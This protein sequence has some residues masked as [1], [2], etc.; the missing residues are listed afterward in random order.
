MDQM[1]APTL[2]GRSLS[3]WSAPLLRL[4]FHHLGMA[5]LVHARQVCRQWYQAGSDETLQAW[6]F[7]QAFPACHRRQLEKAFDTSRARQYLGPWYEELTPQMR[8]RVDLA[9]RTGQGLP[10]RTLFFVLTQQ[11]VQ[12]PLFPHDSYSSVRYDQRLL[13]PPL[14]IS[15]DSRWLLAQSEAYGPER[16]WGQWHRQ[17]NLLQIREEGVGEALTQ[18][19]DQTFL[20]VLPSADSRTFWALGSGG[21][22][23]TWQKSTNTGAW[24]KAAPASLCR[25][26]VY[27]AHTSADSLYLAVL[28]D[29][30]VLLFT[31]AATAGWQQQWTWPL[32]FLGY[33]V[34]M[35]PHELPNR[36]TLLF[37]QDSRHLMVEVNQMLFLAHRRGTDWQE[38]AITG[39]EA[40]ARFNCK[41]SAL[42]PC[43]QFLAFAT[44]DNAH[45]RPNPPGICAEFH[46]SLC[47]FDPDAGW[48][49]I[50]HQ[51]C[52][53]NSPQ[54]WH[55][56]PMAFCPGGGQLAFPCRQTDQ[57]ISLC[58]LTAGEHD[59]GQSR[60]TLVFGQPTVFNGALFCILDAL[61]F[62][63]TG[64][65]LGAVSQAGVQI[66]QRHPVLGWVSAAWV[67]NRSHATFVASVQCVF[68]PDGCHCAL[69]LGGLKGE[70]CIWG[71]DRQGRYTEKLHRSLG[72]R[73][74]LGLQFSPDASQLVVISAAFGDDNQDTS[75]VELFRL[76]PCTRP[77]Q[78][79]ALS[80]PPQLPSKLPP[81]AASEA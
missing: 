64:R 79:P 74:I 39:G 28:T 12:T 23:D 16:Q 47:R 24:Q 67:E 20:T 21:Q 35:P 36:I 65:Y 75:R 40:L 60:T 27:A 50:T 55:R 58:V 44:L 34:H 1:P 62:S 72:N 38:S 8:Q 51:L 22:L 33:P 45:E 57:A 69:A 2:P 10:V 54:E 11:L 63:A 70:I 17:L 53:N 76:K 66:W 49:Q 81:K 4:I 77:R 46:M 30:R 32:S 15:P 78:T 61:Q 6:C 80:F 59:N 18:E 14:A 42:D 26:R 68:S 48:T 37:S 43:G 56:F 31:E 41:G 3:H 71:P 9:S 29:S 5:D 13:F 7:V 73:V 25:S 52:G 19:L